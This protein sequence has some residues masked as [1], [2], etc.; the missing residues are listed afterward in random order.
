MKLI[1]CFTI[2]NL[3]FEINTLLVIKKNTHKYHT[4]VLLMKIY[5]ICMGRKTSISKPF[6]LIY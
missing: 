3:T 1:Y 5:L 4:L 2:Y 6:L